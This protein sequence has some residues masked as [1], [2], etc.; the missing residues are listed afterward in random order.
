MPALAETN[1]MATPPA[2]PPSKEASTA[3]VDAVLTPAL[4]KL[5]LPEVT[6]RQ[7][8]D[9]DKLEPILRENKQRFVLLPIKYPRVWEMY[10]KAEASFWTAEEIDLAS[11]MRDWEKL[12]A[13]EKHFISHVLA[14]FA[15]SDG[16]VNENLAMRFSSEVQLPEA[17][18]FYGFQM[19]MENIHSETYR[20][21]AHK[22]HP[23][24]PRPCATP[25]P[26][27]RSRARASP[28]PASGRRT[29]AVCAAF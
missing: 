2:A 26:P 16:I 17:R 23:P 10:K 5:Q 25:T 6:R 22:P 19:A 21:G 27:S 28:S 29:R 12:T 15:A 13:D 11:D 9:A 8:S 14:F 20:S 24:R 4:A 7:L 3:L 1:L 18:S